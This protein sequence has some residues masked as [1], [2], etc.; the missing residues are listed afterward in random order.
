MQNT[1]VII[2]LMDM[3]TKVSRILETGLTQ[4]QL[5]DLVPCSQSTI[6]A[7]SKG[8]RGMRPSMEIGIRINAIHAQLCGISAPFI[9][10]KPQG[11]A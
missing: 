7:F 4:Q 3:K 5:A 8:K 10:S 1:Y 6:N 11:P 2:V 9:D